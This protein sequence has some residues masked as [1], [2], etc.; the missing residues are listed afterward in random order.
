M[1]FHEAT[2]SNAD[3]QLLVDSVDST[4]VRERQPFHRVPSPVQNSDDWDLH[5]D[6]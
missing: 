6:L 3:Q 5:F 2:N 1:P 4:V